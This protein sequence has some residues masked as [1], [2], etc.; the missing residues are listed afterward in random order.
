MW[1]RVML[2]VVLAAAAVGCQRAQ[3]PKV[4]DTDAEALIAR[5]QVLQEQLAAAVTASAGDCEQLAAAWTRLLEAEETVRLADEISKLSAGQRERFEKRGGG[6]PAAMAPAMNCV[7]DP[8]FR[9]MLAST[10]AALR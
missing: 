9:K 2:S 8:D 1:M 3:E 7:D 10:E 6:D 5:A 4:R